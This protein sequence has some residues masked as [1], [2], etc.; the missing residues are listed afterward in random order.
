[1][2][3]TKPTKSAA[4]KNEEKKQ[5]RGEDEGSGKFIGNNN[6]QVTSENALSIDTVVDMWQV[7]A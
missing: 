7:N 3:E 4:D 5:R 2:E 1:V 6:I